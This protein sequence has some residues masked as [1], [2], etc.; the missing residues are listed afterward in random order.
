L[1]FQPPSFH[2]FYLDVLFQQGIVFFGLMMMVMVRTLSRLIDHVKRR[3]DGLALDC[4]FSIS[5]WMIVWVTHATGWSKPVLILAVLFA[6]S[7][8]LIC[9][10]L[11]EPE[12]A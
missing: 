7:H 10:R 9:G 6:I 8:L 11:D 4:L 2:N 12:L 5:G 1:Q 3:T